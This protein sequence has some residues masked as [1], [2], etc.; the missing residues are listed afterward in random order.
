MAKYKKLFITA[1]GKDIIS[2]SIANKKKI[3]FTKIKAGDGDYSLDESLINISEL[4]N[5]KQEFDILSFQ[6]VSEDLVKIRCVITNTSLENEYYLREMGVFARVSGE[7]GAENEKLFAL[8]IAEIPSFMPNKNI[9]TSITAELFLKISDIESANF[10]AVIPEGV[11][12]PAAAVQEINDG[13]TE[14]RSNLEDF[15]RDS[16]LYAICSSR[17]NEK[18]K[19]AILKDSRSHLNLRTGC[20][21]VV[22]FINENA[23][24]GFTLNIDSTRSI[25][26]RYK[27]RQIR[28]GEIKANNHYMLVYDG[29]YY[30][31]IGDIKDDISVLINPSYDD[32]GI[33][34][35][36]NSFPTFLS[37]LST[38][39]NIFDFFKNLKAGLK[40]VLHKDN[41]SNDLDTNDIGKVLSAKQGKVLNDKVKGA[42]RLIIKTLPSSSWRQ[43]GGLY[44]QE[45][46]IP[47]IKNTDNPSLVMQFET[48]ANNINDIKREFKAYTK[49]FSYII[50]GTTETGKVSFMALKQPAIDLKIGLKGV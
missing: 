32:S 16:C 47:E 33:V 21:I 38:G 7:Q 1:A 41:I 8:A 15:E 17:G 20:K 46:I 40:F 11:Y 44:I 48:T 5:Q 34:E 31:I 24:K 36:I 29:S 43:F 10:Q 3:E 26:V 28:D 4:R 2:S 6:K 27:G 49:N 45:L 30:E 14:I 22:K 19:V 50:K 37:T 9:P 23:V 25:E 13:M 12:A 39:I 35:G 42:T 18:N